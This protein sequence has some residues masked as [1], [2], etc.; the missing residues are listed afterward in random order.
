MRS[1]YKVLE[2]GTCYFITSTTVGFVPIFESETYCRI[3]L[4]AWIFCKQTKDLK[5]YGYVIMDNHF[6]MLLS[7]GNLT[8]LMKSFKSYTAKEIIKHLKRDYNN[9]VLNLFKTQKLSHKTES[10]YQIW[11]ESFHPEQICGI[12]MMQQKLDYI[13]LNP[14]RGGFVSSPEHWRYSSAAYYVLGQKVDLEIDEFGD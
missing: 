1:S 5:I 11:Q 6:H 13:H 14:V 9:S 2:G 10:Q 3:L 12:N 4:D 7:S 8:N